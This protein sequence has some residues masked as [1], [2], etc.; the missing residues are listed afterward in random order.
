MDKVELNKNSQTLQ[1]MVKQLSNKIDA[2][3]LQ[4]PSSLLAEFTKIGEV[5]GKLQD[6]LIK[7][8]AGHS[9]AVKRTP[10]KRM[11]C[12]CCAAGMPVKQMTIGKA[13]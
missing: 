8:F 9:I 2:N 4:N 5:A 6:N 12:P 11:K 13:T 1:A 7:H 3:S 10:P